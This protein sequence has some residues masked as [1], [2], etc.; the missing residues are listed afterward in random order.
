MPAAKLRPVAAARPRF[1]RTAAAEPDAIQVVGARTHNLHIDELWIPKRQLVVFTGVSGSGKSSLAFDTLY[2]EGQRRY[3]ESLSAYARQFL[4]QL[5]RPDVE[6]LRGLSPTI[7][8]EQKSASN[9]PRSTVGTISEI[10]DYLRVLYA[11]DR[12]RDGRE[13]RAAAGRGLRGRD[14]E[15]AEGLRDR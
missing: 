6:H 13:H 14:D 9:N 8:I 11:R 4:G 10:Y 12:E 15:A 3:I 7:A 5:D 1:E 2:A